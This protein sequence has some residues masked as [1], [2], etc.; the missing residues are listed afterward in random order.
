V[1]AICNPVV[2][3]YSLVGGSGSCATSSI[4]E[5]RVIGLSIYPNPFISSVTI[6]GTKSA[7]EAILYD[8]LGKEVQRWQITT[9][10]NSIA[11]NAI[12]AGVYLLSV[13]TS[14]GISTLKL[15][16]Q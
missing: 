4:G 16:K 12:V 3:D 1:D 9:G 15:L 6:A 13:K 10:D 11:T 14:D 2:Y 5:N 8:V 7:G